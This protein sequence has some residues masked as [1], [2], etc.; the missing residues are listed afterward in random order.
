MCPVVVDHL[1]GNDVGFRQHRLGGRAVTRFPG[2]DVV[3]VTTGAVRTLFLVGN[4]FA[5]HRRIVGFRLE[6][7]YQNR[8]FL[9]LDLDGRNAVRRGI[10]VI[11]N[12]ESHFLALEQHLAVGKNHLLVTGQCRH[13]VQTQRLEIGR[14]QHSMDT[15]ERQRLF[16]VDRLHP[17]MRIG[18]ANEITEQHA[19]QLQIVDII[20]LALGEPCVLDPLARGSEAVQRGNALFLRR[21]SFVHYAD[22]FISF[23]FAAAARMDFTMFW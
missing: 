1:L 23:I 22:S 13:P 21:G 11:G 4:I 18:R 5:K 8:Q 12:N 14:S 9:I 16:R 17:R 19:R 7:I 20:T 6:R 3:W 10:T 15:R 2:E